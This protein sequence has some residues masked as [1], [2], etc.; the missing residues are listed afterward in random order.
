MHQK[1]TAKGSFSLTLLVWIFFLLLML[2]L[3]LSCLLIFPPRLDKSVVAL[4]Y[5][6]IAVTKNNPVG[7][8]YAEKEIFEKRVLANNVKSQMNVYG[9]FDDYS[10][11]RLV[12]DGNAKIVEVV[13][14]K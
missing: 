12:Y 6:E 10:I 9:F 13:F 2:F 14:N 11:P 4:I 1:N 7:I 5:S 3:F 8:G